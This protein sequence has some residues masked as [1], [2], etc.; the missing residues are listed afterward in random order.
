MRGVLPSA[1][2]SK[3]V[4]MRVASLRDPRSYVLGTLTKRRFRPSGSRILTRVTLD[5]AG[6]LNALLTVSLAV[7]LTAWV[8]V[9][10]AAG[11]L[12]DEKGR[13]PTIWFLVGL[14]SGPF[15]VL[16]VG[17]APRGASGQYQ[18]RRDCREPIPHLC[19]CDHR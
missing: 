8:L 19:G 10:V 11:S 2:G 16:L 14:L 12:A 1:R 3:A 15:A 4:E 5:L 9:A 6:P 17:L 13:S 7:A 18:R